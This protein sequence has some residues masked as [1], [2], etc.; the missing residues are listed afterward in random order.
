MVKDVLATAILPFP[1]QAG[2]HSI[3]ELRV[4]SCAGMTVVR[5]F[6]SR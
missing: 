2:I 4:P 6:F 1:A 3:D 5:M